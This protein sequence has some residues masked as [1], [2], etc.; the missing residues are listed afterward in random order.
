VKRTILITGATGNI[1]S[2]IFPQLA[3]KEVNVRAFVRSR[4]KAEHLRS[5]GIEIFEGDYSDQDSLMA[6]VTNVDSVLSI[7]PAN[8]NAV[9]QASSITKLSKQ[10]GVKHIIRISAIGAARDAP[11]DNGR[12]HYKTDSEIIASGVPYTI[13]RPNFYMQVLLSSI[14]GIKE[15]GKLY[16]AMGDA[17]IGMIDVRDIADCAV[18]LLLN[19]GHQN[20][21]LSPTGASTISFSEIAEIISV[22]IKR[23]VEYV[24]TQPEDTYEAIKSI[25]GDIWLA[26]VLRDYSKA[27]SANWGNYV[28]E[29]VKRVTGHKAR[30]FQ[31]FN[32]EI[33][34]P[35]LVD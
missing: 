34:Y 2:Y 12:L 25:T 1:A 23:P 33:M 13:L 5:M 19:G 20:E 14:T 21:T 24:A 26:G 11:T 29:D 31:Q 30:S 6:A 3:D 18:C 28:N 8:S 27:Y 15:T 16:W 17:K 4:A 35:L 10:A 32:D 7:T 22:A 9:A